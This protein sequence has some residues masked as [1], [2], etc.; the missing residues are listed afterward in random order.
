MISL[1]RNFFLLASG[2]AVGRVFTFVTTL[3]LARHLG[4]EPFGVIAFGTAVLAYAALIVDFGFDALGPVEM[5]R[6]G[7]ARAAL[8][9]TVMT[10]RLALALVAGV[11]LALFTSVAPLDAT[12]A[13][14]VLA[15]GLAL[16]LMALDMR[17]ALLGTESMGAAA[18]ADVLLQAVQMAGVLL[19]VRTAGDLWL[20]PLIFVVA[21]GVCVAAGWAAWTA[22]FGLPRLGIH[23]PLARTLLPAAVPLAGSTAVGMLL[24]N[25]DLVL[26]GLWLGIASAG[27]YGAAYRVV[28]LPTV[29]VVAYTAA[30]RP[31]VVRAWAAGAAEVQS[32]ISASH[33]IMAAVGVGAAVAGVILARPLLEALYGAEY[34]PAA[35]PF[36][37]L[38][39]AL[40]LMLFS[41][42]YRVLLVAARMQALDFRILVAAAAVNVV[43]N[44]LLL[45]RFG[46]WG[47]AV[48]TLTSEAVLLVLVHATT[49]R[50]AP[51]IGL[52]RHLVRPVVCATAMAVLLV[53]FSDWPL[54]ARITGGL[55]A[56]LAL[57]AALGIFGLRGTRGLVSG[58]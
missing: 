42:P 24:H 2:Q 4:A 11:A 48:A 28:W 31:T 39:A 13:G 49:R 43:G 6:D 21:Q 23:V 52:L 30:L 57:G 15:F 12:T 29:L 5:A 34:A 50:L 16:P 32:V 19:L 53:S 40:F 8:V 41:R 54:A 55:A 46:L 38:L 51:G 7:V 35:R 22:R 36:Q 26:I 56:Y 37:V 47:A 25:F 20:F 58:P 17:W 44:V 14:V 45:P 33:R 10:M 1:R 27:L 9:S 3:Y 18:G